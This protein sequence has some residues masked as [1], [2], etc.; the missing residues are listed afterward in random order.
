[1]FANLCFA[2]TRRGLRQSVF[3]RWG[4]INISMKF[5]WLYVLNKFVLLCNANGSSSR[6][7]ALMTVQARGQTDRRTGHIHYIVDTDTAHCGCGFVADKAFVSIPSGTISCETS[8]GVILHTTIYASF[9]RTMF[10]S[11]WESTGTGTQ[12]VED[13]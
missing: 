11:H 10:E 4:I 13:I 1:M 3:A 2:D 8:V 6:C 7:S 12:K 9:P 5:Y